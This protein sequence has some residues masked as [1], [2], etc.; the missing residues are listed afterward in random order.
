M[1]TPVAHAVTDLIAAT[2]TS[3]PRRTR[4]RL[5]WIILGVLI[6]QSIVGRRIAST[7]EAI[8]PD[9]PQA[10]S[11]ERRVRR[12]WN[13]PQLTWE[14]AYAPVIRRVLRWHRAK[15]LRILIDESGHTVVTRVL[16]AA[17]W[18]RGRAIPLAW[19]QWRAQAPLSCSYWDL[20]D[21][22]LA[23]VAALLTPEQSVVVI[24]D[25]A[26][27][28]PTFTDRLAK[29][30]WDWVVRVQGQTRYQDQTGRET[31]LREVLSTAGK[32]WR[33]R[34]KLFN[35][36]TWREVSVVAFWSRRHTTP[37][38]L[39]R[40][41]P[42]AWDLIAEYR[43]RSAIETLF[44]DWKQAGWHW[45]A[46]QVGDLDHLG[47]QIL[48]LALTTLIVIM[49]G[50]EAA[51][52]ILSRPGASRRTRTWAGKHSLFRLG[53]D[54]IQARLWGTVTTPIVWALDAW[55]APTWQAD[56]RRHHALA[57]TTL[58]P[59]AQAA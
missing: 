43:R 6:A 27:G 54:R 52:A 30:G 56:C 21:A 39:A 5:V 58:R 19:V 22:L 36:A 38:L 35:H 24:A 29:Q 16:V 40:S 37:L 42:L 31:P 32:R 41:V 47:V 50:D 15:R 18:Y 17:V 8:T 49:Q 55:D 25:R 23:Q 59:P 33:G 9:S 2:C 57:G 46:S 1:I 14:H 12:V 20:T 48:V 34:G 45:E 3:L 11:H 7:M 4:A 51:N 10:A 26:F 13:D 44:R 53:R 28:H